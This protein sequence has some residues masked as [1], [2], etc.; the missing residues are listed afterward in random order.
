[1]QLEAKIKEL[2]LRAEATN[3]KAAYLRREIEWLVLGKQ[4]AALMRPIW[5][6]GKE[7]DSPH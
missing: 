2:E 3:N 5:E 6:T 1:M 4:R 7:E